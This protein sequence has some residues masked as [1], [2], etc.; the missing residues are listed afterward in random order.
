MNTNSQQKSI[1]LH[2]LPTENL[3]DYIDSFWVHHNP[4]EKSEEIVISP[5]GFFK[6]L[7]YVQDGRIINYYQTGIWTEPKYINIP[8][9]T[10]TFGCRFNLLAPEYLFQTEISE[11]TNTIK[12]LNLSFLN[13]EK[14]KYTDYLL[15]IKQWEKELLKIRHNKPI[16][17]H[18]KR[19]ADLIYEAKGK[20]NASEVANQAY[21]TNRSI[22]RYLNRYLGI[23]LKTYLSIQRAFQAYIKIKEG[24]LSLTSLNYYDQPHYI[25]EI[26]RF[27]GE[28][29]KN[30]YKGINDR[31][32]QFNH[33]H[34]K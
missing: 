18:K 10:H 32:I 21:L 11:L 12:Q 33:I 19:L 23:S 31:F 27:T 20:L 26:K 25:R 3:S 24:D 34:I 9:R 7:I 22:N 2:F 15:T 13:I 29:P 6:I 14:F 1:Y 30:I 4:R 16:A 8:P 5:D 17:P 28:S